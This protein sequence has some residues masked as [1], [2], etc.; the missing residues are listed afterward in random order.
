MVIEQKNTNGFEA[1]QNRIHSIDGIKFFNGGS[2]PTTSKLAEILPLITA[3]HLR[4]E[5]KVWLPEETIEASTPFFYQGGVNVIGS[6]QSG[7]GTILYGLSE[8]CDVMGVGYVFIDGHHQEVAGERV[9][10]V[11]QEAE[12][13]RIPVFYDSTD[14]LFLGSRKAGCSIPIEAQARKVPI[15]ME[16]LARTTTP[17]AITSHDENWAAVNLNLNLRA[18][19][20]EA[21]SKFP[22][23]EIPTNLQFEDSMIRFLKDNGLSPAVAQYLVYLPQMEGVTRLLPSY[24]GERIADVVSAIR[25]YPVLKELTRDMQPDLLAIID[26]IDRDD[27]EAVCDLANLILR[28]KVKCDNLTLLR[29]R[30]KLKVN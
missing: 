22:R 6:P 18:Q 24:F 25:T 23:Y 20:Q 28:A 21:L 8:I 15:V 1:R 3:D 4:E 5:C 13:K 19:H 27:P 16:A 17:I 30:K 9:A 14:Y 29:R 7:K 12:Q 26:R 11:I 2:L 10:E